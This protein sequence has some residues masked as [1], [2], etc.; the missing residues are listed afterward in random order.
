[1]AKG[2][3]LRKTKIVA[4]VGPASDAMETLKEMIAAGMNVA[5]LNL[6][7]GTLPEHKERIERIRAAAEQFR[8]N[9]A[10]MIDTRGIEI[11]T[12]KMKNGAVDLTRGSNFMLYTDGRI[13]DA[14]GVSISYKKLPEEISIGVPILIC[15]SRFMS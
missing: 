4:T 12:G 15:S 8:A 5:R 14:T 10:I 1:M 13:G 11:R 9:I 3:K 7:F 2:S 6:S